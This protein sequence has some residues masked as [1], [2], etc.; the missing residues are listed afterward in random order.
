LKVSNKKHVIK[1][2][3]DDEAVLTIPINL[4]SKK[5]MEEFLRYGL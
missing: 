5:Y 4:T 1:L 2:F 3:L